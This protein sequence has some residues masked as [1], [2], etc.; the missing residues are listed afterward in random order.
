MVVTTAAAVRTAMR[1]D[2]RTP[3]MRDDVSA[4][5]AMDHRASVVIAR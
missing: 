5:A 4:T 2:M 3:A 1:D